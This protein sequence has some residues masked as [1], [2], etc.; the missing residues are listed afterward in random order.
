MNERDIFIDALNKQ[1][2]AERALFLDGACGGNA[3]LREQV[4]ALLREHDQLG[5]F[6]ESPAAGLSSPFRG[7]GS[8]VRQG[9]RI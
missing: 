3:D 7:E 4:E 6:L 1:N 8:G 2:A 9:K 5:S